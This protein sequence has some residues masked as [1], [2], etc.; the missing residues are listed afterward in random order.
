VSVAV[1][2]LPLDDDRVA[3]RILVIQQAAYRVEAAFI[4]YASIP[5]LYD[6]LE[7]L[8]DS[9]EAFYG[10]YAGEVLAGFIACELSPQTVS[11]TRLGVHP[12]YFR[13]GSGRALLL[14]VETQVAL[15]RPRLAVSTGAKNAPARHLYEQHG[16]A[17]FNECEVEPGLTMVFYEKWR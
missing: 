2:P 15:E 1:R 5:P 14:Y 16:F 8:R 17:C 3:A 13:R 12:D 6:T 11:I 9:G 7:M 4:G 10:A